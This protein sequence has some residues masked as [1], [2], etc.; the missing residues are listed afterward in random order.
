MAGLAHLAQAAFCQTHEFFL[1]DSGLVLDAK[2]TKMIEN[3]DVILI[4]TS[5]DGGFGSGSSLELVELLTEMFPNKVFIVVGVLPF[6][7]EGLEAFEGTKSWLS[8]LHRLK[9]PYMIYDNNNYATKL[10]PNKAAQKVNEAFVNDLKVLQG[11]FISMTR[12]GG[13]DERDMLTV[14][15][16]PGRIV[17]DSMEDIEESDIIDGSIIKTVKKHIEAE[18][19]HAEMVSDKEII[20]SATMYALGD[21]FD[22]YKGGV[23]SDLQEVFGAHVKDTANFS[24]D[25]EGY[26][27]VVLAGL[28]E[29]AMVIDRII[30]K[31]LKL[32]D[33]ISGRKTASSK[34]DKLETRSKVGTVTAKQS[35]ADETVIVNA[36]EPIPREELL[37]R[38]MERKN[39]K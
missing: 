39:A 17:I 18:S 24:D 8:E 7:D 27:A 11:D 14:L 22:E 3:N 25:D 35:F 30:N 5:T 16:V 19:A 26:V 38:F 36:E 20:T 32:G 15:S 29:P 28:T 33:E 4:T 2:F 21:V 1:G 12:T 37:K 10:S 23:K 13:I 9:V 6:N 34:R 31:S